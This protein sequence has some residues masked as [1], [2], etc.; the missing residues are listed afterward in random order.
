M[1]REDLKRVE[2]EREEPA[3]SNRGRLRALAVFAGFL[4]LA[5]VY[6]HPL[7]QRSASRIAS[8][9]YDPILNASILW[10]NATT[11]PFS[12]AWWNPPYYYPSEGITTFTEHLLGVSLFATPIYWLTGNPLTTYNVALFLTWP[13]SAWSAYLLAFRLT[14][15]HDAAIL[16]GLA[17]G[18]SP[19]RMSELSHIQS[20]SSQWLPLVLLGLHGFLDTGQARWLVLAGAAWLVQSLANGYYIL[21]GAV[22]IG[23]WLAYFCSRRGTWRSAPPIIGAWAIASLPLAPVLWK[24]HTVHAFYGL[25]R[26][27]NEALAF[28]AGPGAW[29]ET[30]PSVS[31][32]SRLL[33]DGEDKLFPGVTA[34]TLVL[35]ASWIAWRQIK[36]SL[37]RD[38]ARRR[39]IRVGLALVAAATFAAIVATMYLGPWRI[40]AGQIVIRM[41][42]L[43][44]AVGL[45]LL[46]G[47]SAIGL[48]ARVRSAIGRRSPFLFYAA[49]TVVIA[50][51][52]LGPVLRTSVTLEPMPYRWLMYLPG[53]DQLRVP[54]RFWM[55]GVLCLS[56]AVALAFVRLPLSR[57]R[58]RTAVLS[59]VAAGLLAD[60]WI[61]GINMDP[62]PVQWPRVER[63]DWPQ[64]ILELPLGPDWDAAATFRSIR[65]R[66]RVL[67]GV[68]GYDPPHYGPLMSGL[69]NRDPEL[70]RA[71]GSLGSFD[72]VVNGAED[73]DGRWAAYATSL[74]GVVQVATDGT[75]TAYRVPETVIPSITLGEALPIASARANSRGI[76][77]AL[78][79]LT[80]TE[81]QD[82]PQ[83]P[84]QWVIADLGVW[85]EVGGVTLGMGE[86]ARDYPRRLAIDL[87]LDATTWQ[88][89]WDGPTVGMAFLEAARAPTDAVLRLSFPPR[90]ARFVQLRQLAH[91]R[92][93]WRIAEL[94]VRRPAR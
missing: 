21:F 52:C 70:L 6:T 78:D 67:N 23:L 15:R 74:A 31:L 16:A 26:S 13:L 33:P 17:Y 65:H 12:E 86:F 61:D 45:L 66:R 63:R 54:T 80:T 9:P 42:D 32:W 51:L 29:L 47:G 4:A 2:K 83:R 94:E 59:I 49:A 88:T 85:R 1:G 5:A 43:D 36:P 11:V 81:W 41:S 22:L 58:A 60:G 79:G 82:G 34:M 46:C 24:Y 39:K 3:H 44:R 91:H 20:L 7:L 35:V 40:E 37:A 8:D 27:M 75:R 56:A 90:N 92:N 62:A 25:R 87:S 38:S 73:G 57:G 10:W 55:L 89:V 93:L 28:S 30:S 84:E 76:E 18:F 48:S 68:S 50:V 64:P 72:I 53:F 19:Y 69:E 14:R 77:M 71:I